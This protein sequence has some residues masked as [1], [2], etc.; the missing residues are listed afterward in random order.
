MQCH[1]HA[2]SFLKVGVHD[3]QMVA[4][5]PR[6][7]KDYVGWVATCGLWWQHNEKQQA[8]KDA[9]VRIFKC[10]LSAMVLTMRAMIQHS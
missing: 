1:H 4:S 3:K 10:W 8:T 9:W 5:H 6:C 2:G 7:L